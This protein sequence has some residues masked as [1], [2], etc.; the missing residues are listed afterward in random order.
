MPKNVKLIQQLI[1]GCV[2]LIPFYKGKKEPTKN[3]QSVHKKFQ[4][5]G[6]MMTANSVPRFSSY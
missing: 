1:G 5:I 2:L 4:F 3:K 6:Q